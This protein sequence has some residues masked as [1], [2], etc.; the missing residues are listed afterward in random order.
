MWQNL[1][2][3]K[4][5]DCIFIDIPGHGKA[6]P[7]GQ[8]EISI[9]EM[10]DAVFESIEKLN[11]SQ[12]SIVGH[13]LGGYIALEMLNRSAKVDKCVLM[14]SNFWNDSEAKKADRLRVVDI[15]RKNK[16]L[17]I[18][19]A[20]PGLFAYPENFPNELKELIA[21][22]N[23]MSSESIVAITHAM[24]N[25]SDFSEQ[26]KS[27]EEKIAIIQGELDNSTTLADMNSKVQNQKMLMLPDCGHMS[28]F[29]WPEKVRLFLEA[30]LLS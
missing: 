19:A 12:Y 2:L 15:V 28:H 25:R 3:E 23:K 30:F 20:L 21:E 16:K 24:R 17:F 22:A 13:S 27:W 7:I 26:M 11:L 1:G 5:F 29:E 8:A 14:N 4:S 6:D 9:A 18:S 10:A